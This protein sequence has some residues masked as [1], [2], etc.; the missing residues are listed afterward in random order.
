MC[1]IHQN[2][3]VPPSQNT[4][5]STSKHNPS[6]THSRRAQHPTPNIQPI[7]RIHS[8]HNRPR[9]SPT[10][11]P[12]LSVRSTRNTR[13]TLRPTGGLPIT[14]STRTHGLC[15]TTTGRWWRRGRDPGAAA[16]DHRT[17]RTGW[18]DDG[19]W[20]AGLARTHWSGS[21][22]EYLALG[23]GGEDAIGLAW[24]RWALRRRSTR[25]DCLSYNA[26]WDGV[27]LRLA[28]SC[29]VSIPL[30]SL[31]KGVNKPP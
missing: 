19:W 8:L 6:N 11:L 12:A 1:I 2:S 30:L 26:A 9:T 28:F 25:V 3:N 10:T 15:M 21:V 23:G 16:P 27:G 20:C 17:C 4:S 22:S 13:C 7:A 29:S 14:D 31:K 18:C 5:F 24:R